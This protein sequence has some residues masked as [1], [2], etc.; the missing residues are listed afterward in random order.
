MKLKWLNI[1][2]VCGQNEKR[3][4][5]KSIFLSLS[6][7][8]ISSKNH[9]ISTYSQADNN[10]KKGRKT[11]KEVKMEMERKGK[12]KIVEGKSKW[13]NIRHFEITFG[14]KNS[15]ET[16]LWNYCMDNLRF[17]EMKGKRHH[18][19]SVH[20]PLSLS[21]CVRE[22]VC[23]WTYFVC[24]RDGWRRFLNPIACKLNDT[25]RDIHK[26]VIVYFKCGIFIY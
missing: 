22:C 16:T 8:F 4:P 9:S 19:P 7:R 10:R 1:E 14:V 26:Y 18:Q 25:H 13:N 21:P 5:I 12:E 23:V 2:W 6:L 3:S 15:I 24:E 17:F 20:L 11:R